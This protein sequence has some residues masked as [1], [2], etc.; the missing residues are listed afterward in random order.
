[1]MATRT[2]DI[3]QVLV[4]STNLFASFASFAAACSAT[5][6]SRRRRCFGFLLACFLREFFGCI[7]FELFLNGLECVVEAVQHLVEQFTAD[8]Q[9]RLDADGAG[10]SPAEVTPDL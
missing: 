4:L 2:Q 8:V 10:A 6:T 7:F 3:F 9:G 5:P 1:M